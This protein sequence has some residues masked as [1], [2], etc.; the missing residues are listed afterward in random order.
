MQLGLLALLSLVGA[1]AELATLGAVLP[2][3]GLLA[4]P[5]ALVSLPLGDRIASLSGWQTNQPSVGAATALFAAVVLVASAIRVLLAWA[6]LR[7]TQNFGRE[8]AQRLYGLVLRKPY[9][10]HTS[11][12]TSEIIASVEKVNSIADYVLVPGL[13]A[14]VATILAIAILAGL[15]VLDWKV[16][17]AAASCFGLSYWSISKY[18]RSKLNKNSMAIAHLS[19]ERVRA[20]QEGLG[21]I[22]DVLLEGSQS[23]HEKRFSTIDAEL[24]AAQVQNRVWAQV[25]RY[26]VEALGVGII[27]GVA[28]ALAR[29]DGG[30]GQ[31]LPLLAALAL[32]AQRLLPLFQRVY[33][34]WSTVTGHLGALTDVIA[35]AKDDEALRS[36]I[37]G[38][39]Q[40]V[41]FSRE[42]TLK[43]AGYRHGSQLPWVFR[44]VDLT[45]RRGD[46]L[47]IIG[48][49]GSGKSTLLDV[50]MGL[51]PLTEGGITVDGVRLDHE[52]LRHWRRR[53]AHVPQAIFLSDAS[54]AQNIAL[55]LSANH[56]DLVRVADAARRAC[57]ADFIEA[58]PGGYSTNVGE[59]GVR[60]SGGQRQRIGIARALYR[61]AD[62]IVLDE[63]TSALD[64]A[65]EQSVVDG[66]NALGPDVTLLIVA[67]R[68]SSLRGCDELIKLERGAVLRVSVAGHRVAARSSEDAA[69]MNV[70]SA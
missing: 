58:L 39:E 25:P 64:E 53:I 26:I 70:G 54:I 66:I 65:T 44:D 41:E 15:V 46:R 18:S 36:N 23:Y 2:F 68:L 33:F 10:Y 32:G 9:T 13:D 57:I 35:I 55:G 29:R 20:V 24:R 52:T 48:E 22:R 28:M 3:I 27:A 7:F 62:V 42:L 5:K 63:A 49:T 12:N 31:A 37:E 60:L 16:A 67:H 43:G 21:G 47:G 61:G 34:G 6:T 69:Q 45:I 56:I 30:V 59:R 40:V 51:L 1:A 38:S 14:S 17:L 19:T 8:L 50:L 11:K 4:D